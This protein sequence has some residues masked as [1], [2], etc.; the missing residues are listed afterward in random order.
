M[1]N[2]NS[3]ITVDIAEGYDT[4][5]LTITGDLSICGSMS[6]IAANPSYG[7]QWGF[8]EPGS[9]ILGENA[10]DT[11]CDIYICEEWETK[12]PIKIKDGMCA[13]FKEDLYSLEEIQ[14]IVYNKIEEEYP[15]KAIKIGLN[16]DSLRVRK[17]SIPTEIKIKD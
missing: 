13:S 4:S 14:E 17:H 11:G 16:K 12:K 6:T 5:A 10:V 3:V 1:D 8:T 7:Q 2:D 15:E 9:L